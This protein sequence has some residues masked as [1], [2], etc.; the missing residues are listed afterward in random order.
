MKLTNKQEAGLKIA[1]TRY[2]NNE[3]YTCIAGYAGTGKSTLIQYIVEALNLPLEGVCYVAYT[4]K[5][6]QVLR[7]KNC[8]NAITA[9]RLLYNSVQQKDG[10][11]LF[12]PK[13]KIENWR[14]I[15]VDEVS[16]IPKKMWEL[17]LS[18]HIHVIACGDPFQ[19]PPVSAESCGVLDHPHI[20][21]DEIMRQEAES[22]IIRLTMDIR[23]GKELQLM[24][25]SQIKIVNRS[26][27][28][29]D[30]IYLWADQIICGRN[31]T[32]RNI[33]I[34]LHTY[35]QQTTSLEPMKGDKIICLHNEWDCANPSGDALVNGLSGTI[36]TIDFNYRNPFMDKTPIISFL[37]EGTDAFSKLEVDYSIFTTG[38]P[39]VNKENFGKI[40]RKYRPK[41]FD[42]GYAITAWKAQGSEWDKVLVIDEKL[43][44]MTKEEHDK[45]LYTCATRAKDKLIIVKEDY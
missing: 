3:A 30:G 40:I 11:F 45:F 39:T 27:L 7:S 18:H 31:A 35:L 10:S 15:V 37:P 32:R 6:A 26:E 1:V 12:F 41:Q 22:D 23:A 16:M 9:H 13:T 28:L 29:K 34:D 8:P 5:A 42:F 44:K 21:L 36:Q 20:F 14:L 17:L 33:N 25:T 19:L 43:F 38:I 24:K 4:G 2:K